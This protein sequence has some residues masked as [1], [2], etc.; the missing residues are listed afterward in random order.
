MIWEYILVFI[1]AAIP[2]IEI[3]AVIPLAIIKGLNPFLVALLSFAGNFLTVFLLIILF[4]RFR[5]WRRKKKGTEEKES[6]RSKRGK[7]IWNRYG[8]PGLA[9]AGPIL[10]GTH[11]AAAIGMGLGAKKQWTTLWMT[12]SLLLWSGIF[13]VAAHYG[14]EFFRG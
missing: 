3:A 11:I 9:L 4:E 6:G 14:F 2:W 5:E 8:L 1:L 10:I 7:K 13:A 12:I